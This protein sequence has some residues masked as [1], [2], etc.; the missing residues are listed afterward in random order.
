M[1]TFSAHATANA[2]AAWQRLG[3]GIDLFNLLIADQVLAD[4]APRAAAWEALR[5]ATVLAHPERLEDAVRDVDGLASTL[6][7]LLADEGVPLAGTGDFAF[8]APT[9]ATG[10]AAPLMQ[11]LSALSA[12]AELLRTGEPKNADP[13]ALWQ[14][15]SEARARLEPPQQ[16]RVALEA[17]EAQL[18]ARLHPPDPETGARA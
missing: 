6:E 11:W 7:V 4:S 1:T 3:P 18:A 16:R 9:W 17:V 5:G 10:N 8:P 13:G 2:E 12:L 15:A 14:A